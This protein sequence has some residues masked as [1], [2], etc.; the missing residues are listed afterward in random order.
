MLRTTNLQFAYGT[1][2]PIKF[3]DID[4]PQGSTLL[5]Q[6]NSGSGKSTLLALACG[7]LGASSGAMEVAGQDLNALHGAARDAWR[8][9]KVGFVPQRLHLSESLTVQGNLGLAF[10]AA[11]VP[12]DD[13]KI[14]QALKALGVDKLAQ[15][16]PSQL[17]GGQAQRVA[18]A[19]AVLLSP[20][21]ILA[22]EPTASLDDEAASQALELLAQCAHACNA[23]LVLATH[24]ARVKQNLERL[25]LSFLT[26]NLKQNRPLAGKK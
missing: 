18:L 9:R 21:I 5:L 10:Y 20:K 16:R 15:R 13:A 11:G 25:Q 2:E 6:G 8:G 22:D 19:R 7:L 26:V 23:T 1:A 24:D 17:S 12:L 14:H 4:A 3:P